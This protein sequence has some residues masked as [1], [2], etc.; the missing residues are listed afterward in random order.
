M[1]MLP[2]VDTQKSKLAELTDKRKL[3]AERFKKNPT[4]THLALELKIIDDQVAGW[5]QQ[6]QSDRRRRQ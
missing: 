5:N 1:P 3:L 6:I 2:D 4:E